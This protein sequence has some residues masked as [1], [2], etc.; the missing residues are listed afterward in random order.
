MNSFFELH[1]EILSVAF[2]LFGP[3]SNP[4]HNLSYVFNFY[5]LIWCCTYSWKE[6]NWPELKHLEIGIMVGLQIRTNSSQLITLNVTKNEKCFFEKMYLKRTR[7]HFAKILITFF[8]SLTSHKPLPHQ[9]RLFGFVAHLNRQPSLDV[10]A[11]SFNRRSGLSRYILNVPKMDVKL[12]SIRHCCRTQKWEN[13][14]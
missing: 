10:W 6:R 2:H 1:F 11:D 3:G 9:L 5:S 4:K 13:R 14:F 8:L 7:R 12:R